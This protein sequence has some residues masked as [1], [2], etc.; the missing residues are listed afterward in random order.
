MKWKVVEKERFVAT[1]TYVIEAE[2]ED[3]A[4]QKMLEDDVEE[5]TTT[6]E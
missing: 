3:D 6:F 4:E 1:Y 2:T 5:R